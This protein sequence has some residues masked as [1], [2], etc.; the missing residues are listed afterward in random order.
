MKD[1]SKTIIYKIVCN[2][3]G[4]VYYGHTVK[5][6]ED[7]INL[8]KKPSN[9]CCSK[10][11]I[12]RGDYEAIEIEDYPCA[13]VKEAHA[14]ERWW[15][16]NHECI[17]HNIPGRTTKEYYQDNIQRKKE[18]YEANRDRVLAQQKAYNEANKEHRY[19]QMKEWRLNNKEHIAIIN[20]FRYDW[21]SSWDGSSERRGLNQIAVDLFD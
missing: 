12:E 16:E 9:G 14:R 18:Y 8:H 2:V 10:K 7:R 3:T 11:I 4:E 19:E 21:N 13:N 20:K 6:L 5:T 17:N 1:Y 15:I